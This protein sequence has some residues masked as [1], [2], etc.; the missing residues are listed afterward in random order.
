MSEFTQSKVK[1][2][3]D[4]DIERMRKEY[5]AQGIPTILDESL[6]LLLL[7]LKIKKPKKILEIGTATGMSGICILDVCKN[8]KLVTIEANEQ[9]YREAKV[10]FEKHNHLD[11]TTM[12]FGDAGDVIRFLDPG[13][14]FIFLDGAKARYYDY[15]PEL[16]RL[17]V[18]GG[19]LFADN[20]LFRG[21]VEA[22]KPP[23]RDMTIVRNMRA[24]IDELT[25]DENYTTTV[26]DAGDGVLIAYFNEWY[27]DMKNFELLAPAGNF[28][29]LKTAL[30]FGADAVYVGGTVFSLRALSENFDREQL[31]EAVQYT[32]ERNKKL[33]VAVNI[34]AKNADF[35]H[36]SDYLC[37]LKEIEV[38][39]VIVSDPGIITLINE[40]AKGLEIHLSTQ[41]ST[42]NKYSAKFWVDQ[43]VKRIVLARE[44]SL[45]E[46]KEIAEYC[47][48]EIEVF[49]HGAMCIS[50][51][52]RCLLSN[53]L[54]GRDSNRGACVQ[55]CR[56]EYEIREKSK[57]D[58]EFLPVEE[59]SRGTYIF[60]SKDL[61]L[62]SYLDELYKSGACSLKIEGRMKSEYYLATVINAYRRAID[63]YEKTG[64]AYKNNQLFEE[65]LAKTA[66][67]AFTTAY[68]LGSNDQT[69][70]YDDSQSRGDR[71][72]IAFVLDNGC[73]ENGKYVIIEMRNRFVKGDC[74]EV[75]SPSASFNQKIIVEKLY[76]EKG[77]E[78]VDAKLVQQ[79]LKLYTDVKLSKG[80]ILRK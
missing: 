79:K 71:T 54:S 7:T 45:K 49:A 51:S 63:E 62:I 65:E 22:E 40:C 32:H 27:I 70:N 48:G 59:D 8:A 12:Y 16:K 39:A 53:Y 78:V 73:D 66:H 68:T 36:L 42:L 44:L 64:I 58:G 21:L 23:H 5:K 38:D 10:N 41:A 24:F 28:E 69:V 72:F 2:V 30:Y 17:L 3:I 74:L 18:K 43:G 61:N 50:Y 57:T 37:Y 67:R 77:Y 14:D 15:L 9:S 20:V 34:L 13:F 75:L 52:G 56:W 35:E 6:N 1:V 25:Q 4:K 33:Y 19:V 47:G 46:V 55:C 29:K 31:K 60:N 26:I 76:D 11:K 80:D